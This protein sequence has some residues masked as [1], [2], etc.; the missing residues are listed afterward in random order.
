MEWIILAVVIWGVYSIGKRSGQKSKNTVKNTYSPNTQNNIKPRL[1]E[2]KLDISN[3]I[4]S[5]EQEALFNKIESSN[6]HIFITGKAGTG[7]SLL[8]QYFKQNSSKRFVVAA[9]TGVAALNVGAQTIHSL[10]R[11]PPAFIKKDSLPIDHKTATLLRNIDTVVIDEISMVR[12][13]LMDAIDYRLRQARANSL[14]FGGV[15]IIMFGDLFQLPPVVSDKELHKYFEDTQGGYFFFNADVW[16]NARF[17]IYEL[18]QIFRQKDEDFK[19]ILNAIREGDIND[20]HLEHLNQRTTAVIPAE[21]V[22]TLATTNSAVAE[23]NNSRLSQL[24]GK[25][26]E[27]RAS[28]SGNLEESSFPTEEVL[29]LKKG[30]QVMLLK[31]DRDKRWVNGTLGIVDSLTDAEVKV[32]IDGIVYSLPRETW[33]KIR[34]YYD[35]STNTVEEETVSSFTQFPL[36]LAW[37]VTIHKSQGQTFSTIAI[38]MGNGAFAHGQT[39]VALSR[40]TTLEGLYLIQPITREHI[41]VEPK[42]VSFMKNKYTLN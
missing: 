22:I 29:R 9:P 2:K 31:N 11:I 26:F 27:Y 3:I 35:R 17:E 12:A 24:D 13:D 38:D 14:P 6:A 41:I 37:A 42:I 4:L 16:K 30:A 5:S 7:K 28:I 19:T 32:N 21:G 40:C 39:Y 20:G 34:Y 33:K 1:N 8:L 25:M 23:I 15:Q 36:R 10:F 18:T